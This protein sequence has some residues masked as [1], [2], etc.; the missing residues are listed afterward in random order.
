MLKTIKLGL[1]A[2]FSL[3]LLAFVAKGSAYAETIIPVGGTYPSEFSSVEAML[4]SDEESLHDVIPG[5]YTNAEIRVHTISS[6]EVRVSDMDYEVET[7]QGYNV[8]ESAYYQF[9]LYTDGTKYT[10]PIQGEGIDII[11]TLKD[12]ESYY[13][14]MESYNLTDF[15]VAS[16]MKRWFSLQNT[17]DMDEYYVGF[18]KVPIDGD[19]SEARVTGV[20]DLTY[21]G[22]AQKQKSMKIVIGGKT[23]VEGIDYDVEY[24]GNKE[25][26]EGGVNL[27]GK[28]SYVGF[29]PLWYKVLPAKARILSLK[30]GSKSLTINMAKVSK[31]YGTKHFQ[32]RYKIKGTK[33][34]K[35]KTV[36]GSK[37]ALKLTKLKK[38][39]R[40]TVQVRAKGY[41]TGKWSTAR[42]SGKIK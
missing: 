12:S 14:T 2:I 33:S 23:L 39:K 3:V 37:K 15:T 11:V 38:G 32:I 30:P 29:L 8:L 27:F 20:K 28:G 4:D 36:L 26:G 41:Y 18:Y 6:A 34:W 5:S 22:K 24:Y 17:S 21:T 40:Y 16:P 10:G 31:S 35:K 1:L 25:V 19:L 9:E 7:V 42:T 13:V